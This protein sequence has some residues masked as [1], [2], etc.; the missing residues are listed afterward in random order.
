MRLWPST[1]ENNQMIRSTPGLSVKTVPKWAKST[2]AWRPGEV[3]K[4]TSNDDTSLGRI[5]R[6]RSV[7]IV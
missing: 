7:R 5:S 6:S 1:I 4:R 2:C 3:S